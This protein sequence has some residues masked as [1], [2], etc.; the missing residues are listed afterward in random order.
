MTFSECILYTTVSIPT[1]THK[2]RMIFNVYMPSW[3]FQF[4]VTIK[5][6]FTYPSLVCSTVLPLFNCIFTKICCFLNSVYLLRSDKNSN[7]IVLNYIVGGS[8]VGGS[9]VGGSIVGGSIVGGQLSGGQ[10]SPTHREG[11]LYTL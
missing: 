10:L 2:I 5:L 4:N 6:E 9:I 11:L 7:I 3:T 8:I 1:R